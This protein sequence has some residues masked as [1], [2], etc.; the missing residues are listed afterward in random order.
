MKNHILSE[1]S[2][3]PATFGSEN[4]HYKRITLYSRVCDKINVAFVLGTKSFAKISSVMIVCAAVVCHA[5]DPIYNLEDFSG[6]G[7]GSWT[8]ETPNLVVL[9]NPGGRL[10]AAHISQTAPIFVEDTVMLPIASGSYIT[11][12][13]F[14]LGALDYRP[15]RLRVQF[16]SSASNHI[17]SLDLPLPDAGYEVVVDQPIDFADGWNMGADSSQAWFESDLWSIDWIGIK[18]RRNADIESQN[19]FIDDFLV[20]GLFYIVD[21]D[22]DKI[23]DSWEVAHGLSSND[24]SDAQ[25]DSDG[26][27]VSNYAEYRA[28]T[29]PNSSDSLFLARIRRKTAGGETTAFELRWDSATN[30]SYTVWRSSDLGGAF[31]KLAEGVHS[32]PPE[33]VYSDPANS[34]SPA[35]FYQIEVEPEL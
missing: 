18:I 27:G 26:D 24:V 1:Y 23:A 32:M 30:R 35:Y 2:A 20:R 5:A 8:N 31:Y 16:H 15:S 29:D 7:T 12:I 34:N 10:N 21:N 25:L 4:R 6:A 19:Y 28:G 17:W 33:N 9:S 22:L 14:R 11:Q 3:N 13:A